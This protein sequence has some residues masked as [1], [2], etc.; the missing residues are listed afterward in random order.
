MTLN[1]I[2][3]RRSGLWLLLLG[4]LFFLSYGFANSQASHAGPLPSVVFSWESHIPFLPWTI[5]PYWSLDLLYALSFLH[6]RSRAEIDN[7]GCRLLTAQLLAVLCFLCFPLQG[8]SQHPPVSGIADTLFQLL[9]SF[10]QPYN[11]APSLHIALLLIV[12]QRW[13]QGAKPAFRHSCDLGLIVIAISPLTTWQHHFIDIPTGALLGCFCLWL[14]PD[15]PLP[16][17]HPQWRSAAIKLALFYLSAALMVL[18]LSR[19]YGGWALWLCWLSASLFLLSLIY[20]SACN[21]GFQKHHGRHSLAVT[22]LL[23][24]YTLL[25]WL[26]S[27]AWTWN[28]P[29][30]QEI[31]DNVWIDRMPSAAWVKQQHFVVVLDLCAELPGPLGPTWV[32]AQRPWLDLL[33]PNTIELRKVAVALQRLR[34]HYSGP[35]LVCCALGYSRSACAVAGW[36]LH[37]GR[38]AHVDAAIALVQDKR[39]GTVLTKRHR[40]ALAGLRGPR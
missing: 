39:P 5:I 32:Y 2:L 13:R 29:P 15:Q 23:A 22:L 28:R 19:H 38:V 21:G 7:H 35:L 27:R 14:W 17:A 11:Q 34:S 26:N 3:W 30:A 37:S 31:C 18:L 4:P 40:A 12:W 1:K 25:A 33:P 10:D 8:S 20:F 36:L 6:C 24:P 16:K 9:A